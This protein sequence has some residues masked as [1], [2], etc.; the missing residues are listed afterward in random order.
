MTEDQND[1]GV[2]D[3]GDIDRG[4]IN[5]LLDGDAVVEPETPAN[6]TQD[7]TT[8]DIDNDGMVEHPVQGSVAAISANYEYT[9]AHALKHTLSH[10]IGHAVGIGPHNDDTACLMNEPSINWSRDHHFSDIAADAKA[11]IKIHN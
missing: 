8:F 6:F 7:L 11:L 4:P 2:F 5:S 10:E 9:K 3:A 1:N